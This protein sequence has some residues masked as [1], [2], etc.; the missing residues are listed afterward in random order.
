M[1]HIHFGEIGGR[2]T[3]SWSCDVCGADDQAINPEE[4]LDSIV[5]HL[6][7]HHTGLELQDLAVRMAKGLEAAVQRERTPG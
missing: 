3:F 2:M 7:H 5:W 1:I 6:R 4:G